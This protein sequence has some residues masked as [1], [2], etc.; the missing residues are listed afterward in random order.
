[1]DRTPGLSVRGAKHLGASPLER[2]A[3]EEVSTSHLR[4][5]KKSSS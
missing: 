3:L 5:S 1:M 4:K 2:P